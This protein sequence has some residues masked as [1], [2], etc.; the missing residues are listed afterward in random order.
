MKLASI[1]ITSAFL[2]ASVTGCGGSSETS[3]DDAIAELLASAAADGVN[4]EDFVACVAD[5][6]YEVL[7]TESWS[8]VV[9]AIENDTVSEEASMSAMLG[10]MSTLTEDELA[11]FMGG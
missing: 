2:I 7:G 9:D 11:E 4:N 5:A 3:R 8:D 1:A 6:I 10:C